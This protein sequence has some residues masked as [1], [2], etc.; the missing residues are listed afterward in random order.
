[1][2]TT[3][4]DE[5]DDANLDNLLYTIEGLKIMKAVEVIKK[6]IGADDDQNEWT[7]FYKSLFSSLTFAN[8]LTQNKTEI[9][10]QN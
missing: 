8:Y 5:D 6:M 1:M 3:W 2:L 7:H 9:Y 4:V 10:L